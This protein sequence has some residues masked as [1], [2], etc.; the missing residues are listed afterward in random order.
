[1]SVLFGV[2]SGL[3]LYS[4]VHVKVLPCKMT[5]ISM[6]KNK[7]QRRVSEGG[8][9]SRRCEHHLHRYYGI[10]P[11][12]STL[13]CV[14]EK[15]KYNI[16]LLHNL[17][18]Q[19]TVQII[20]VTSVPWSCIKRKKLTEYKFAMGWLSAR[21]P[22]AMPHSACLACWRPHSRAEL[23]RALGIDAARISCRPYARRANPISQNYPRQ[24]KRRI[25]TIITLLRRSTC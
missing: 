22:M 4:M 14:A 21:R 23:P 12:L 20:G 17:V 24:M 8:Y 25:K 10:V 18:L 1:M 9:R 6:M 5:A 3:K 16:L 15:I 2:T 7:S 19:N 13:S 11:F